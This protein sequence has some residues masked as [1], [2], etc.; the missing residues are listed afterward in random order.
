MNGRVGHVLVVDDDASLLQALSISLGAKGYAVDVARSGEEGLERLGAR[1]DVVLLDLGLP[2]LDGVEVI[3]EMR[4][5]SA[6]PIIVL[7]ARHQAASK[8][9]ALGA[10]ADAYVTKPFDMD[11]LFA[12]LRDALPAG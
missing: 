1:T 7:S 2:G 4:R 11:E 3:R 9:E 8:A 6:I 10:G 12:V 5:A